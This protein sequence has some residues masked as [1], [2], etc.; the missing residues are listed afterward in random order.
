MAQ[1]AMI[2]DYAK[3]T[4]WLTDLNHVRAGLMTH[5]C[6][7]KSYLKHCVVLMLMSSMTQRYGK[8]NYT[9]P[10]ITFIILHMYRGIHRSM[11]SA[12]L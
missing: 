12:Y 6:M 8:E 4:K 5:A 10:I 1:A 2:V 9:T 7:V 3:K 11:P